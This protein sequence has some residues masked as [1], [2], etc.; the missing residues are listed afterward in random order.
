MLTATVSLQRLGY[1]EV[2]SAAVNL[3]R[4][5]TINGC[6]RCTLEDNKAEQRNIYDVVKLSAAHRNELGRREV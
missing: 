5:C 4:H 6:F 1:V 3:L 2:V